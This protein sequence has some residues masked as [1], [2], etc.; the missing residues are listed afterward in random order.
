[1]GQDLPVHSLHLHHLS[2]QIWLRPHAREMGMGLDAEMYVD[3]YLVGCFD[4]P[5]C[6]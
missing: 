6:L 5:L 4:S 2:L 1:M 3:R